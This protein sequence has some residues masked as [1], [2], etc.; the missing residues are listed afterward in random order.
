[1]WAGRCDVLPVSADGH[2]DGCGGAKKLRVDL[3]LRGLPVRGV[4]AVAGDSAGVAGGVVTAKQARAVL[5]ELDV[6]ARLVAEAQRCDL[7][8][9]VGR[10]TLGVALEALDH[11]VGYLE[12]LAGQ[13]TD[14]EPAA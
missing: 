14:P 9:P 8:T 2:R 10:T 11:Q 6:L 5:A 12:H 1:M 4:S 7:L 13:K 3:G